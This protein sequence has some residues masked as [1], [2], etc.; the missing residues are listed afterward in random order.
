[1]DRKPLAVLAAGGVWQLT[2]LGSERR[3]HILKGSHL[4][5]EGNNHAHLVPPRL[6]WFH[7]LS[8]NR[9]FLRL[10]AKEHGTELKALFALL[11]PQ[12][13]NKYFLNYC[14]EYWKTVNDYCW[15]V[16]AL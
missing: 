2:A 15:G 7:I 6:A 9:S 12:V 11:R 5:N 8:S 16:V 13:G 3:C 10:S 14:Y 1:M 4:E